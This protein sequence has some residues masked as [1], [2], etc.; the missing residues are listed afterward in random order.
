MIEGGW[1]LGSIVGC[2]NVW[3]RGLFGIVGFVFSFGR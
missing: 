3:M 1:G 2:G